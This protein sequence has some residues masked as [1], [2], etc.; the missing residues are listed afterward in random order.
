MLSVTM[1]TAITNMSSLGDMMLEDELA[2]VGAHECEH[3]VCRLMSYYTLAQI[4]AN[5]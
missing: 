5:V 1:Q 4:I 3:I 2:A